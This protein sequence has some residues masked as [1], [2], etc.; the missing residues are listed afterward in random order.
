[1]FSLSRIDVQ[2]TPAKVAVFISMQVSA[3]V[4]FCALFVATNAIAFWITDAREIANAFTYGGNYL[5]QYPLHVFGL[6]F[7][8]I[9]GYAFVLA[10][11]DYFPSLYILD[12]ADALGAPPVFRFLSPVAAAADRRSGCAGVALGGPSLPEHGELGVAVVELERIEKVFTVRRPRA[13]VTGLGKLR[14]E[15]SDVRAVDDI[16]FTIEPGE[17]VGYIGPNGAGKSTTI[18]MLTGI[19]VP[20]SGRVS[21][22]GLEPTRQR[23]DLARRNSASCS[24][25]GRS[26]GGTCPWPT[27]SSCSGT[28]T[29]ST[30]MGTARTSRRSPAVSEFCARRPMETP[31]P[32]PADQ[33]TSIRAD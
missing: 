20:S 1:M 23:V 31:C 25:S 9:L 6:W 15:R 16:S 8:R 29:A 4:I 2:W 27:R 7:R 22:L 33:A 18:K 14:R 13:G 11:I 30:R 26:S 17:M 12:K 32:F 10:W 5:T 19:L 21:V 28:S 3:F 24:V